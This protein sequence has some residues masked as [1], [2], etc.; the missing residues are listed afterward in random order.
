MFRG[1]MHLEE[2]I[3]VHHSRTVYGLSLDKGFG[4]NCV[5]LCNYV[6]MHMYM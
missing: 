4:V 3:G 2:A 6:Y 5:C 1:S